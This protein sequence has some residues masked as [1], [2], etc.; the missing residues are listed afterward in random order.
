MLGDDEFGVAIRLAQVIPTI[1]IDKYS[2][3]LIYFYLKHDNAS[4]IAL[5]KKLITIEVQQTSNAFLQ[6]FFSVLLQ[7]YLDVE[8]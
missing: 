3:G 4:P 6:F 7:L 5:I 2:K 1:E 8:R